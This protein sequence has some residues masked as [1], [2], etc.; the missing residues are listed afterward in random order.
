MLWPGATETQPRLT[1]PS[2]PL[3]GEK[4]DSLTDNLQLLKERIERIRAEIRKVIIGQ[5]QTIDSVLVATL[6]GQHALLEGP[7]GV[8]IAHG[9]EHPDRAASP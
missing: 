4:D 7:P 8:A 1:T 2:P 6:A 9:A 5:K 3:S